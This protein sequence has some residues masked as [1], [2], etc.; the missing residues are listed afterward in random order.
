MESLLTFAVAYAHIALVV[1][2]VW[3]IVNISLE[4]RDILD[5]VQDAF[6][7][8]VFWPYFVLYEGVVSLLL[9]R[10]NTKASA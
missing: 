3:L 8:G 1:G 9:N 10:Q 2:V 5:K 7:T 4:T 6:K